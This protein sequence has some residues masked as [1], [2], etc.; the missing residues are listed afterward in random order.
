MMG[1]TMMM[2][3]IDGWEILK[4]RRDIGKGCGCQLANVKLVRSFL[5]IAKGQ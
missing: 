3:G 4:E 1:M 2:M 5:V